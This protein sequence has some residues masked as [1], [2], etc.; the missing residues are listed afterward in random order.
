MMQQYNFG[1]STY[2]DT[3]LIRY[4]IEKVKYRVNNI[5]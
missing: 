2:I 3:Y 1:G 5:F 4:F